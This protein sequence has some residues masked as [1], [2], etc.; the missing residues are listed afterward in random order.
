M[1]YP[2]QVTFD[3]IVAAAQAMIAQ[4]G[5]ESLSLK[6]LADTLGVKAPS[7]YRYVANKEALLQAVNLATHGDLAAAVRRAAE[8]ASGSPAN[9]LLATAH[10]YREFAHAHAA[11]YMLSYDTMIRGLPD[12]EAVMLQMAIPLQ[13]QMTALCGLEESLPAL[14]GLWALLHGYVMLELGEQFQR[15]GDLAATFTR[16]VEAYIAGWAA[17]S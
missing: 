2:S 13:E 10:A 5:L 16:V 3:G 7:L 17:R 11:L 14:R 8:T 4:Q 9:R 1:P 6:R 15:G 12:D